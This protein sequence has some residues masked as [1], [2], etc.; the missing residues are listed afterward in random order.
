M[1]Q[2][3]MWLAGHPL[4]SYVLILACTIYIFNAVF[5]PG[6]LPIL[7]EIVVYLMMAAG[8]SVLLIMQIDRLPI[9]QCMAIAVVMMLMLR[10]RQL[11]D[12]RRNRRAGGAA[13]TTETDSPGR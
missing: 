5:R 6:R 1:Q 9:L 8:C 2:V 10:L 4:I 13:E 7:K 3:Q 12:K 11:Y